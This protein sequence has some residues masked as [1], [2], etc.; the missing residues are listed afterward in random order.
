M[1]SDEDFYAQCSE[2][3]K[4]EH[5]GKAFPHCKRTRW[6]NRSAGRGRYPGKGIIRLF[7]DTV[8]IAL[9]SPVEMHRTI[10]GRESALEIL[11]REIKDKT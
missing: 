4:A 5:S 3:L 8:Q 6:N 9:R 10:E 2:I 7:G 1:M 11:T